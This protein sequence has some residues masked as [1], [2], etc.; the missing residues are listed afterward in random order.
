M[1]NNTLN[2]VEEF[3]RQL[4]GIGRTTAFQLFREGKVR[5]VKIGRRT[6]VPQSEIDRYL[7]SLSNGPAKVDE[8]S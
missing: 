6:L 7:E 3:Q 8:A 1:G 4:G 5:T 2:P